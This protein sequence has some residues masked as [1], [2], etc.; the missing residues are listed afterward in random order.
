MAASRRTQAWI[1][2]VVVTLPI[3]AACQLVLNLDKYEKVEGGSDAAVD[4]ADDGLGG[5]EDVMLPDAFSARIDWAATPMPNPPFDAGTPDGTIFNTLNGYTPVPEGGV[6]DP[7]SVRYWATGVSSATT[8]EAAEAYCKATLINGKVGRLP[9][10]VELVSLI[11]FTKGAR[12]LPT[13][14]VF[15]GGSPGGMWTSSPV[16]PFQGAIQYWVVD[17]GNG[18]VFPSKT[19]TY[20]AVCTQG[21]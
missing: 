19:T 8:Y 6:F 12:A 15:D 17:F 1:A 20:G 9:S 5:G 18:G 10:R 7:I 4:A 11:D 14:F 3:V 16:R 2:T 21:P 13:V